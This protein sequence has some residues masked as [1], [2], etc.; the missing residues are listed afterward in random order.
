MKRDCC[1]SK[2]FQDVR[3]DNARRFREVVTKRMVTIDDLWD[4]D[5]LAWKE[6]ERMFEPHLLDFFGV[7]P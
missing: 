7:L 5:T 6:F 2:A 1:R 4:V 3:H